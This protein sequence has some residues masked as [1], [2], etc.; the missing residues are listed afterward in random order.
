[1]L[2]VSIYSIIG[3]MNMNLSKFWK[4]V[5]DRGSWSAAVHGVTKSWTWLRDWIA[6]TNYQTKPASVHLM[7]SKVNLLAPSG[8]EGKYNLYLR[9][10]FTTAHAQKTQ[11][12]SG[13]WEGFQR[14][15]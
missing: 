15:H 4:I 2:L 12:P 8:T 3:S 10:K 9:A 6:I 14:Q 1:M 13:F 11:L 5:K 7:H